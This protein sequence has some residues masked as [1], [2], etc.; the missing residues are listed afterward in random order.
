MSLIHTHWQ[1][2]NILYVC[3]SSVRSEIHVLNPQMSGNGCVSLSLFIYFC[4][5]VVLS[6]KDS[7]NNWRRR[8]LKGEGGG[9][10]CDK[11]F[12]H[13]QR[14]SYPGI[15]IDF[16]DCSNVEFVRHWQRISYSGVDIDFLDC[17]NVGHS[18]SMT[19]WK[20]NHL[21]R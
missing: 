17:S 18:R 5:L 13:W 14:I 12:R 3:S 9:G 20:K 21:G 16:L 2:I 1:I 11:F 7:I 6:V 8:R 4:S 15:D 10:W 19:E